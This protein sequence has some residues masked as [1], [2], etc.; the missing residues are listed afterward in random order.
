LGV[1]DFDGLDGLEDFDDLDSELEGAAAAHA[2]S[3]VHIAVPMQSTTTLMMT[4]NGPH[5]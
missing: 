2:A 3:P 1:G 5:V 4:F